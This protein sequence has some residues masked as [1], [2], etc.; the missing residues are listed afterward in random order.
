MDRPLFNKKTRLT[1]K[2]GFPGLLTMFVKTKLNKQEVCSL[3]KT[4]NHVT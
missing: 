1:Y 3:Y 4:M 2:T